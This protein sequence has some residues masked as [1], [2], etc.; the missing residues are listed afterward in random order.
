MVMSQ[1]IVE[2]FEN[3]PQPV[4][5]MVPYNPPAEFEVINPPENFVGPVTN[6]PPPQPVAPN[7]TFCT[8]WPKFSIFLERA[9]I[10]AG[11]ILQLGC[12]QF[13]QFKS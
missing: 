5:P 4:E 3:I 10:F 13:G 8:G 12:Q 11:R 2:P 7:V 1:T 6:V 9:R